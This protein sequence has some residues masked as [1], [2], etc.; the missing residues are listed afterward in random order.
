MSLLEEYNDKSAF[1]YLVDYEHNILS[2][3]VGYIV[4]LGVGLFL[5]V[6]TTSCLGIH[7]YITGKRKRTCESFNS[8][9]RSVRTG[10]IAAVIVSQWTWAATILQ[11]STVA[12]KY[13][14]SGPFWYAAGAS[15]QV[16]IF[17]ILSVE[18]KRK[19]PRAHTITEIIR[20]RWGNT[21][22]K[23]FLFFCLLTNIL[24]T[25]MLVLGGSA[26]INVITGLPITVCNFLVPLGVIIYTYFDGLKATFLSA[27]I[28]ATF[29]EITML[30]FL[31]LSYPIISHALF[32]NDLEVSKVN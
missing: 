8:A 7:R 6:S 13:G 11:S 5:T 26:T 4:C 14:I 21:A 27:Y 18:I 25:S 23:T 9:G 30:M 17:G 29:I 15:I 12:W 28:N 32:A 3:Y 2:E 20:S 31:F 1:D 16:I 10:L 19:A 24:V 22:H